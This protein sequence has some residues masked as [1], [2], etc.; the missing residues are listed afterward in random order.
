MTIDS[1]PLN[2][3]PPCFQ[4]NLNPFS[5][6]KTVLHSGNNRG[7]EFYSNS[8]TD[9]CILVLPLFED[10]INTLRVKFKVINSTYA[11]HYMGY[12]TDYTDPNTFVFLG[13]GNSSQ[14][15][16]YY[17]DFNTVSQL[18]GNERFAI[19]M[20]PVIDH[21]LIIDSLMV[22]Y[23][24]PCLPPQRLKT[25]QI[26]THQATLDWDP[27]PYGTPTDYDLA[28]RETSSSNWNLISNVN[29]PYT[30]IGLS[31]QT[32]YVFKV[33]SNCLPNITQY[34]LIDTFAT[35]CE[36]IDYDI[37]SETF[38]N[39]LPN[40]CWE[41]KYGHLY[42]SA[43]A[44]L[45]TNLEVWDI[46]TLYGPFSAITSLGYSDENWLITPPIDLGNGSD[47][48]QLEFD[49]AITQQM[50]PD[51][52]D[53]WLSPNARFVVLISTDYGET[54]N[55]TGI[56]K[57]WNNYGGTPFNT[58]N[59]TLQTNVIPLFDSLTMSNYSGVIRLAFYAYFNDYSSYDG[60]DI[61]IDNIKINPRSNCIKPG[62]INATNITTSS[63]Q[64][65]WTST[66]NPLQY[67]VEYG[68]EG[69][70]HGNGN[71]ISVT[72][73]SLTINS[74]QPGTNYD[75]Y[76][77]SVCG[78]GDTSVWSFKKT[79]TTVCLVM[80]LP[81]YE[82]F[83]SN[84]FP[85][86]WKQTYTSGLFYNRWGI[87]QTNNAGGSG[88]EA[89]FFKYYSHGTS[90]LISP[91]INISDINNT[92]LQFKYYYND[93]DYNDYGTTIKVQTST[94]L[95][96]WN[97]QSFIINSG[98]GNIGPLSAFIPL[99][100]ISTGTNYIAWTV[101]GNHALLDSFNIDDIFITTSNL[102][103]P[104]PSNLIFS[105]IDNNSATITWSP[106]GSETQW[107]L[108]YKPTSSTTWSTNIVNSTPSCNIN[109][110]SPLVSYDVKV[111][112]LC[113]NLQGP[114]TAV[115]TF[116]HM[117]T[118]T[119]NTTHD[120]NSS[121][122]PSGSVVVNAVSNQTFNFSTNT[123]YVLSM[124][125]IDGVSQIP[126]PNTYTFT[127]VQSNHT[128]NVYS[129]L[130]NNVEES[131]ES[132]IKLFPNPANTYIELQMDLSLLNS[133]SCKIYNWY[134]QLVKDQ[135]MKSEKTVIDISDFAVGV[136]LVFLETKQGIYTIKFVKN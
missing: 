85:L 46:S 132:V 3:I 101:E 96:T 32:S 121:I 23:P 64:L 80:Q 35:N 20:R 105:S 82:N 124:I 95:T 36:T 68:P 112:A 34:S 62:N 99:N 109:S 33:K 102:L 90:R 73:N 14:N 67:I 61:Y 125:N 113:S 77:K 60:N 55:S 104:P 93:N 44:N 75:F 78:V 57:E 4:T 18:T 128:I 79:I 22:V 26:Q 106:Q 29:P 117:Q 24:E 130:S 114:Y 97:D 50:I 48:K 1:V 115:Q 135:M 21:N 11:F 131:P 63:L 122:S 116:V 120:Y 30:L 6:I 17:Y 54:W 136:Y 71:M 92:I 119:I 13:G 126:V 111:R 51:A 45:T 59:S 118:Y 43:N 88:N 25:N 7:L 9:D 107:E 86:C 70:S 19:N 49:V 15:N 37:F 103:C 91:A 40:S 127:N 53:L 134:G 38:E 41:M 47:L 52:G 123:G 69:F 10:S 98:S 31:A 58:L 87:S 81:F 2:L 84:I 16:W 108:A 42:D 39:M 66:G 133:N 74:L 100:N 83:N 8:S 28:Y 27:S 129:I 56:L 72:Q 65:N 12:M 94:N 76:I 5:T 110:L 89:K